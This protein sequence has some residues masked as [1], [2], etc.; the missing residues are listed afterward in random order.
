MGA[1]L[2]PPGFQHLCWA[3]HTPPLL[4]ADPQCQVPPC[5]RWW[6]SFPLTTCPEATLPLDLH[7]PRL[8]PSSAC[9]DFGTYA[10]PLPRSGCPP[11]HTLVTN[12]LGNMS[13]HNL[14]ILP[15]LICIFLRAKHVGDALPFHSA[16]PFVGTLLTHHLLACSERTHACSA[17]RGFYRSYCDRCRVAALGSMGQAESA[18]LESPLHVLVASQRPHSPTTTTLMPQPVSLSQKMM[19]SSHQVAPARNLGVILNSSSS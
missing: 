5:P 15:S 1:F 9:L 4:W 7:P 2:T 3:M 10:G 11:H 17:P 8:P 16:T 12:A 14:Y 18:L 13:S 19:T 6:L